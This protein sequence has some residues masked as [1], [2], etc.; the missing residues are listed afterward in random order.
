ML[1]VPNDKLYYAAL[2]GSKLKHKNQKIRLNMG[3]FPFILCYLQF[4]IQNYNFIAIG[5]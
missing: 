5:W 1:I 4:S 2:L 3:R